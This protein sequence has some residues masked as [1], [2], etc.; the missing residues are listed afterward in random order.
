MNIEINNIYNGDAYE[1]IKYIP[2]KS[3]DCIYTDIPYSFVGNGINGGGGAFGSKKRDYHA[4]Y[5]QVAKRSDVTGIALR[6]TRHNSEMAEI[7]YGINLQILD[8]MVRVMKKINLFIW[9]SKKQLLEIMTYFDKP[10]VYMELL[11]WAKSNPIPAGNNTWLSD[12]EYLLHFRE[13][14]VKLNDGYELKSKFYHSA[15]NKADKALY[16]HP[17]IKPAELVKR[18][19]AHATQ[20]GDV[21]LDPFLGSGTT[22]VACR[23]INRNYIGFELD[24]QYFKIAKERLAGIDQQGQISLFAD[25][26]QIHLLEEREE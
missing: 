23:E 11:V 9:C 2:D 19:L 26:E 22:A 8:E 13:Q 20:N 1:F 7:S 18:H 12:L 24:K 16:L 25:F 15:I 3:I 17:T 14:G 21:I 5:K 4:E 6:K 10:N